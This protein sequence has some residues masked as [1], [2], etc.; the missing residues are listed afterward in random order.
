MRDA[1][2]S[3]PFLQRKPRGEQPGQLG[4]ASRLGEG[5]E[6][7]RRLAAIQPQHAQHCEPNEMA[8]KRKVLHFLI[9][10]E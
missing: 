4:V 8:G 6:V 5:D 2:L 9:R 10:K 7:L 1:A 3:I